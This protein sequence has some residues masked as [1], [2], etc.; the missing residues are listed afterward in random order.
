MSFRWEYTV[1]ARR[2]ILH[3]AVGRVTGSQAPDVGDILFVGFDN[4]MFVARHL[5]RLHCT[6]NL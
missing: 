6:V 1:F 4:D 3:F 2:D 5:F